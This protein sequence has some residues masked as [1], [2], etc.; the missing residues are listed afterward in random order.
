MSLVDLHGKFPSRGKGWPTRG[1]KSWRHRRA[2]ARVSSPEYAV[3]QGFVPGILRSLVPRRQLG[4][5][6]RTPETPDPN[7]AMLAKMRRM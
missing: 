2:G 4:R 7:R 5:P 3:A 1:V 6:H